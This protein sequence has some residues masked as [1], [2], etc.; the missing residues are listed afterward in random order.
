MENKTNEFRENRQMQFRKIILL[1]IGTY[2]SPKR[3]QVKIYADISP[4]HS[5]K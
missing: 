3:R 5:R 2:T 1:N 4:H